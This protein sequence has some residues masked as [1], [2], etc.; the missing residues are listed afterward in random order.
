MTAID[1]CTI[2]WRFLTSGEAATF[3]N[4]ST[5]T[6]CVAECGVRW[7]AARPQV[8][9]TLTASAEGPRARQNLHA[10]HSTTT[11]TPHDCRSFSAKKKTSTSPRPMQFPQCAMPL[12]TPA[13]RER[14]HWCCAVSPWIG[15]KRSENTGR[16]PIVK[17]GT[18]P[19]A[20]ADPC[21][22]TETVPFAARCTQVGSAVPRSR[23]RPSPR[24]ETARARSGGYATPSL[25]TTAHP[26]A[27]NSHRFY[28]RIT[29]Q[30]MRA[31]KVSVML[32]VIVSRTAATH[33]SINPFNL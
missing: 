3:Q 25:N 29:T 19:P 9:T 31:A 18:V 30:P 28:N 14:F 8:A 7:P 27:I 6:G 21:N 13:K 11:A 23:P 1:N 17:S 4:L 24:P 12:T 32:H 16:A 10:R 2:R 26:F 33:D 22:E 20:C 15:P 5:V